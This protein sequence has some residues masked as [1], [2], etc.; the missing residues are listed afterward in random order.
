MVH[1]GFLFFFG[2]PTARPSENKRYAKNKNVTKADKMTDL[3][4]I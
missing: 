2:A 4:A 1:E 3:F